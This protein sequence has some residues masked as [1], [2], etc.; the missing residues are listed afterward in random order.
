MVVQYKQS[1]QELSKAEQDLVLLGFI[2]SHRHNPEFENSYHNETKCG[3][4]RS[5]ATSRSFRQGMR[6]FYA[7]IETCLKVFLLL[8]DVG[9]RCFENLKL[10][11]VGKG[12]IIRE[13][14]RKGM[15]LGT[16]KT[17]VVTFEQR[18]AVVSFMKAYENQHA[19]P[20]PG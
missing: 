15:S 20:L 7:D 2:Q 13:H 17:A 14:A 16:I 10:F 1:F 8:H 5:Q 12:M 4:S 18:E 9:L 6:Y 3:S 19:I 11:Y